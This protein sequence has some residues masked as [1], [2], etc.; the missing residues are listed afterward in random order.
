MLT[1]LAPGLKLNSLQMVTISPPP[2]PPTLLSGVGVEQE[3]MVV[4]EEVVE[5]GSGDG[6]EVL[7]CG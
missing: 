2:L 4:E 6:T 5:V 1:R 7:R 3:G